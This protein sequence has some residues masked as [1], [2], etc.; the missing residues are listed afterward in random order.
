MTDEQKRQ[1]AHEMAPELKR[2]DE[3]IKDLEPEAED[4]EKVTGGQ[5][6]IKYNIVDP[7]GP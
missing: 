2:P 4:S 3:A 1:E 5:S 7:F 6:G